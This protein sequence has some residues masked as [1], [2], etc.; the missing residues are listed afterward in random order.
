MASIRK[1]NNS[2]EV[3]VSCGYDVNGKQ[4]FQQMTW[5]P[6]EGMTKKQIEKEVNRQAVLFEE[7]CRKGQITANVKFESFFEQWFTEYAKL[8]LRS[9]SYERMRQLTQRVYPAIGH[10]RIDKITGRHIQ[11][12]IN[13]LL[14]NGKSQ[15]T[16]KPL[17]RKTVVHHLSF[18]SD[19][20]SYAVKMDMLGEN[21]CRKVTVPKGETS[22]KN[23][24]S[25]EELE[26]LLT[27]LETAPLKYRLFFTMV[28]YT[29]FRRSEMLG[30]EWKDIDWENRII[31]VRRTSNYTAERGIYTDTTK[32]KKSQRSQRYLQLVF[33]LLKAYKDEQ[34]AE[35]KRLG[36]QWIDHDRLFV[37]WNGL[38]MNNGTPYLWLKEL[39]EKNRLRFCDI[40]S[41]RHAHASI[42][43]NA[44]VDVAT[45]SADLGH[46]NSMTTLG[47]YTHEF[48]EAQARTSDIIAA[49]LNFGKSKEPT[50]S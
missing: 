8:N 32:T 48:Q 33:D 6:A 49:A 29:G 2:Y 30:L 9:T 36:S 31:S 23:I 45:V 5:K 19:V 22:E 44:G 37:K 7:A 4:K 24:Y 15:K 1:K 11:Q 39:C 38:P 3:R 43:I 12:F 27:L 21:P 34:D 17:S 40:H 50:A 16:G 20:F 47:I 42:L 18:I 28:L 26:Q 13:D 10:M 46:T 41:F 35:R 14:L 25:L